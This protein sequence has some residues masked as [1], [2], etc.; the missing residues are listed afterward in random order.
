MPTQLAL[1][2]PPLAWCLLQMSSYQ[3]IIVSV[4]SIPGYQNH[5][6]R[7]VSTSSHLQGP[8]ADI[9]FLSHMYRQSFCSSCHYMTG[10]CQLP[11]WLFSSNS[12]IVPVSTLVPFG[13]F[14]IFI[15]IYHWLIIENHFMSKIG[16]RS[17]GSIYVSHACTS[18]EIFLDLSMLYMYEMADISLYE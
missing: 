12:I 6:P 1:I 15:F 17:I 4:S 2:P 11:T 7:L 14:F 18:H 10:F 13:F 3:K 8:A 16:N 9:F 5:K